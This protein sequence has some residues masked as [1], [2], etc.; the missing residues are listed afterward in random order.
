MRDGAGK[1]VGV[2]AVGGGQAVE[3]R[4]SESQVLGIQGPLE[5]KGLSSRSVC[6]STLSS[7]KERRRVQILFNIMSRI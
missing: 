4:K 3:P 2:V 1:V 5:G 6:G 7:V